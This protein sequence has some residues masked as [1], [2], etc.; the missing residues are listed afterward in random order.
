MVR[1]VQPQNT[2]REKACHLWLKVPNPMVTFSKTLNIT[3]LVNI[4]KQGQKLNML[5][6]YCIGK[7]ATHITEFYTLPVGN[8]LMQYDTIAVNMIIKNK[9]GDINSCDIPFFD[10]LEKFEEDYLK[11]TVYSWENC[12][13]YDLSAESMVIG[14]SAIIE[15]E[16]DSIVGMNSGFSNPFVFWGKYRKN[17]SEY[18]LPIS[19]QFHHTQMDG[20]HAG[21]FLENL[22]NEINALKIN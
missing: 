6:L 10:N 7:T 14:T 1:E 11:Y 4:S 3:N 19:F 17:Q 8:K 12:C 22:Q 2:T 16:L 15:T 18:S 20:I 5:M 21:R 13:D 9:N